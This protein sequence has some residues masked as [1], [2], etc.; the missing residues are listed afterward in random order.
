MAGREPDQRTRKSP[1][2]KAGQ[3]L[4]YTLPLFPTEEEISL[5]DVVAR[6][7]PALDQER[8]LACLRADSIRRRD[9]LVQLRRQIH[10]NEYLVHPASVACTLLLE[11]DLFVD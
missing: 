7:C 8:V 3:A 2:K 4:P 5:C 9:R 11:G 10:S 6:L 1:K